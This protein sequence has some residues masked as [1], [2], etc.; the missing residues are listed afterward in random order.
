MENYTF[1]LC[2]INCPNKKYILKYCQI[3]DNNYYISTNNNLIPIT[4]NKNFHHEKKNIKY[5]HDCI[6][7]DL[8]NVP[9][10]NDFIASK[11]KFPKLN[12]LTYRC[13][14]YRFI[15]NYLKYIVKNNII[16]HIKYYLSNNYYNKIYWN[17]Y[18][19]D[20][21]FKYCDL[22]S[23]R[24]CLKY[25]PIHDISCY[26]EDSLIRNDNIILDYLVNKMIIYL[27]LLYT[28]KKYKGN[29]FKITN[30]DLI[31]VPDICGTIE[32]III[33][34]EPDKAIEI[35]CRTIDRFQELL[36]SQENIKVRK[37]L[38]TKHN[39]LKLDFT[40]DHETMDRLL[41]NIVTNGG[42]PAIIVKQLLIDGA[43]IHRTIDKYFNKTIFDHA[44]NFIIEDRNL[45]LL[46]VLFEMKLIDHSKLNLIL[47]RSIDEIDFKKDEKIEIYKKFIRE[48]SEYGADVDKHFDKLIKKAK[49][50]NNE[51]LISYLKKF[52]NDLF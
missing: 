23:I 21:I 46:D 6:L 16:N 22:S 43:N 37:D 32:G 47:E 29:M 3:I 49:K 42:N 13:N 20:K 9:K 2:G 48:L 31:Y 17:Q 40:Y 51:K 19:Q 7:V 50:Y 33:K 5:N 18:L 26:L 34:C 11:K 41:L 38:I 12:S 10:F 35:Y 30:N 25:L 39:K 1:C 4:F 36:E 44:I 15:T 28:D 45:E 24:S 52:K 8:K 27:N 14:Y